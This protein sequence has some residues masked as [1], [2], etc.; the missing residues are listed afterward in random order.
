[1]IETIVVKYNAKEYEDEC[2]QSIIDFTDEAY[3]LSVYDNFPGNDNLS[4]I[5]N[6]LI[7]RSN[8]DI[9][10]LVN[11]DTV[12]EKGWTSMLKHLKG[13]VG[14]VG[15]ITNKCGTEQKGFSKGDKMDKQLKTRMLSGFFLAFPRKVWEEV[16]FN[17]DYVL[18]GEDNE[19]C[20]EVK[21]AGYDLL[22]DF[23]THIHH[24]GGTSSKK[25]KGLKDIRAKSRQ[26]YANYRNKR[27]NV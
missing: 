25:K 11:S 2:I 10:V 22:I 20:D 27:S 5:W 12:L 21:K 15:P 23:N 19:W 7:E 3:H 24:Y 6:R 18:Y 14:A 8:A 4:V 1:M 16:K 9:I 17:E 26:Q 13:K